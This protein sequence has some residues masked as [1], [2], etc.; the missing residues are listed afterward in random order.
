MNCHS[1]PADA[2]ARKLIK[3]RLAVAIGSDEETHSDSARSALRHYA[4]SLHG[5]VRRRSWNRHVPQRPS[6]GYKCQPAAEQ[7]CRARA[8]V[9]FCSVVLV[10]M[11]LLRLR[12]GTYHG[13]GTGIS[14]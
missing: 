4:P 6:G 7:V 3:G 5:I 8:G 1:G 2:E 10:V 9:R 13:S 12:L 11:R 14:E